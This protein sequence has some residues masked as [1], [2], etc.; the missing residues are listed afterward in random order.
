MKTHTRQFAML[1]GLSAL[2]GTVALVAQSHPAVATIP[3]GFHVRDQVLPAGKYTVAQARSGVLQ[4]EN[5][6]TNQ[7]ILVAAGGRD[8]SDRRDPRLTFKRYGHEY[9]LY[10]VWLPDQQMSMNVHPST[11]EKELAKG[12][13]IVAIL[14][15]SLGGE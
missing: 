7:F 12:P 13:E 14:S 9:F 6:S 2:L 1:F 5:R 11:R 8:S 15:V 4:L 10:Q 3:F